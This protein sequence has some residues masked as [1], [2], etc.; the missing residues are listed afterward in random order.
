VNCSSLYFSKATSSFDSKPG[1]VIV[2]L[3]ISKQP[4]RTLRES[5][6]GYAVKARVTC[7][8]VVQ[9]FAT[10]AIRSVTGILPRL[11]IACDDLTSPGGAPSTKEE[12]VSKCSMM[13]KNLCFR[14]PG[15]VRKAGAQ[16]VSSVGVELKPLTV[17]AGHIE[18]GQQAFSIAGRG[19]DDWLY[20][21]R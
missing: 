5:E 20:K 2:R 7:Y 6:L 19:R 3:L 18:A 10:I 17:S 12:T 14:E 21:V 4:V 11:G 13:L 8:D 1:F 16:C 9:L 15:T